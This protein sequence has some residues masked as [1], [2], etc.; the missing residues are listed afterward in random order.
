MKS[1]CKNMKENKCSNDTHCKW[2]HNSCV[3]TT[4]KEIIINILIK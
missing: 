3:F 4:T 2:T 1:S